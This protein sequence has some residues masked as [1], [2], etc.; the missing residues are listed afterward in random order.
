MTVIEAVLHL[1]AYE[2]PLDI[3][4]A[5]AAPLFI[6]AEGHFLLHIAYPGHA[7]VVAALISRIVPG[8]SPEFLRLFLEGF[9]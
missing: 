9:R 7:E 3:E 5:A 1:D 8:V 2:F 4:G 6:L